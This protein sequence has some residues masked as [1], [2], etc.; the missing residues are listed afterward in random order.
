MNVYQCLPY[1]RNKDN[2]QMWLCDTEGGEIPVFI[3]AHDKRSAYHQAVGAIPDCIKQNGVRYGVIINPF[4]GCDSPVTG[5]ED[6]EIV[7][8]T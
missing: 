2:N 6:G 8:T 5:I 7:F 1:I 3:A 4:E